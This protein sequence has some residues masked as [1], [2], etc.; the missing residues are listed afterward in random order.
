MHIREIEEVLRKANSA[1]RAK[2]PRLIL[3]GIM[4]ALAGFFACLIVVLH[5]N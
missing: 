4:T 5:F 2:H 3:G 1:P